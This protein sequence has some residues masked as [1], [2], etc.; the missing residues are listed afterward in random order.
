MSTVPRRL[1]AGLAVNLIPRSEYDYS[2]GYESFNYSY[3]NFVNYDPDWERKQEEHK[4][5]RKQIET[6]AKSVL[7]K[8][9]FA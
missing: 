1:S 5:R 3:G 4:Q 6:E 8:Y 2:H 7:Y 9:V